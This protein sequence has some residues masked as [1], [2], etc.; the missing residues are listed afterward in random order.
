MRWFV[1]CMVGIG[2]GIQYT[3]RVD[4][5]V[6]M[7]LMPKR[8]GWG[9]AW[10]GPL[11]SS[12]FVGYMIGNPLGALAARR[13]GGKRVLGFCVLGTGT[14]N[15]L[16]PIVARSPA[17]IC[18]VR[19]L[20]GLV[21][22]A[23]FP[24][25]YH[26]LSVWALDSET[27]RAVA[28]LHA[29]GDTG[30]SL[31]GFLA[32]NSIVGI[33]PPLPR[34]LPGIGGLHLVFWVWSALAWAWTCAWACCVPEKERARL[35]S[36]SA[37]GGGD[38]SG[39]D[40]ST[41]GGSTADCAAPPARAQWTSLLFNRS[42]ASL[43]TV[44]FAGNFL[45]YCLLTELPLFL[46]SDGADPAVTQL[47]TTVRATPSALLLR[48]L[49]S[50][51]RA[52]PH[53][54]LSLKARSTRTL[55]DTDLATTIPAVLAVA[56]R[57]QH[58]GDAPRLATRRLHDRTR[59]QPHHCP[60]PLPV[61]GHHRLVGRAPR[62]RLCPAPRLDCRRVDWSDVWDVWLCCRRMY[63]TATATRHRH[64]TATPAELHA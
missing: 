25:C 62:R 39:G 53:A 50:L 35:D 42:L 61:R 63:A 34:L 56:I 3:M 38:G 30:G 16:I 44:H 60:A 54:V 17:L 24:S 21:Q 33:A 29:L 58:Y 48:L 45:A 5:S 8:Y 46:K 7:T 40:S 59:R 27:S 15:F 43:Y 64:S 20:S 31:V 18:A 52:R 1:I 14:L 51:S 37:S 32:C 57:P 41:S 4:L 28:C 2:A 55:T 6:A 10:D 26:L 19:V 49:L 47:A 9:G 13:F 36:A 11:L 22:A 12:F 23:T